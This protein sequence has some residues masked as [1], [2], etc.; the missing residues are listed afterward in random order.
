MRYL[1]EVYR[2]LLVT[3]LALLGLSEGM[4]HTSH[5]NGNQDILQLSGM[6]KG[7]PHPSPP[8]QELGFGVTD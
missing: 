4:M 8:R 6:P 3:F 7:F 5:V 1:P 2:S